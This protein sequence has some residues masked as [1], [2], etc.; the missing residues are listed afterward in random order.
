VRR[1]TPSSSTRQLTALFS[2]D[3]SLQEIIWILAPVVITLVATQVGT[4]P[5]LL[6]IVVIL[7]GGGAWFILSPRSGACASRAA[8]ARSARSSAS[9]WSCSPR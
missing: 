2:L 9:P 7:V 6:L 5:A 4:V 1:S 3:A 8:A